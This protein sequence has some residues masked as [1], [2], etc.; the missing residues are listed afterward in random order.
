M[1]NEE[2]L[3]AYL[4]RLRTLTLDALESEK[5]KTVLEALKQAI[6]YLEGEM[7]GY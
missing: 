7:T 4:E 1:N 2:L 6:I 3:N 5:N